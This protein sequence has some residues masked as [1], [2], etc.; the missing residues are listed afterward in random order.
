MLPKAPPVAVVLFAA[1]G[2]SLIALVRRE[3]P[4]T[5]P[6]I[7]LDLLRSRP[8]RV[9]VVASVCCFTGQAAAMVALGT[10]E[11]TCVRGLSRRAVRGR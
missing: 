10:G 1:A 7:P 5:A 6:L 2:A 3:A 9:S 11:P 8:F 4:K